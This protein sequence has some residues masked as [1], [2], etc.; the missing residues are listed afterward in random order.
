MG[1]VKVPTID[2]T[3]LKYRGRGIVARIIHEIVKY[4]RSIT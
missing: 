3:L 2:M 4:T 1:E